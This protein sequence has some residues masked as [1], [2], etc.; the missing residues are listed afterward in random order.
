[1]DGGGRSAALSVST[2]IV[3][4]AG[5]TYKALLRPRS[6]ATAAHS[7]LYHVVPSFMFQ[8]TIGDNRG[9]YSIR[10]NVYREYLEEVFSV[11][12]MERSQGQIAL[13][14]FFDDPRLVVL[15]Q[16][17]DDGHAQLLLTGFAVNLLNLRPEICTLLFI[18]D[19]AWHKQALAANWEFLKP[20]QLFERRAQVLLPVNILQDD[21]GI[22]R[23]LATMPGTFV[24]P[25]AAA[26]WLGIDVARELAGYGR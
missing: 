23:Y 8:P 5:D 7:D 12:E 26:F 25:G 18:R 1:M 6:G 20:V 4:H 19:Q 10:Y 14:W 16:L 2:L 3:Y 11:P 21:A 24:P 15:R 9:E 17:L 13:D 22:G